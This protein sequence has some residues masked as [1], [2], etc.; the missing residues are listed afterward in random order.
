MSDDE[1]A[2]RERLKTLLEW[3]AAYDVHECDAIL[4]M[5]LE[6]L[7]CGVETSSDFPGTSP[8]VSGGR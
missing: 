1:A 6:G 8:C 3:G 2:P 7:I 5:D 4:Q